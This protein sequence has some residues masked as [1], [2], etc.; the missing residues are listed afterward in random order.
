MYWNRVCVDAVESA[1]ARV[2]QS[3]GIYSRNL[4]FGDF[5]KGMQVQTWHRLIYSQSFTTHAHTHT[6]TH[7]NNHMRVYNVLENECYM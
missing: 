5:G 2:R 6:H 3:D 1:I 7:S 4:S